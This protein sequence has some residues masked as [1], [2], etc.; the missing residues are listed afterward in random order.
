MKTVCMTIDPVTH[1]YI[2]RI[3]H[4]RPYGLTVSGIMACGIK[5]IGEETH[6]LEARLT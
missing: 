5:N 2:K 1:S 6:K 4:M 3:A